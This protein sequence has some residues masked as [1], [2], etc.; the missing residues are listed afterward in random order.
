MQ[1]TFIDEDRFQSLLTN[2]PSPSPAVVADVLKKGREL[3]G[4]TPEE[5]A[6][7]IHVADQS[8]IQEIFDTAFHIKNTVYGG[9]LV[10]FAPLY[11]SNF[12]VNN[13]R[14]C[15]FRAGNPAPRKK[16][17]IDEIREQTDCL[18][19]MGHKRILLETGEDA[20]NNPID[21]V[22]DAIDAI[23][24]IKN[25]KGEV[26]RVN[27]NIAATTVENYRRLKAKGI[28][29]YQL[30]QESYHRQ[31][32]ENVHYGLKGNYLR[33]LYAL[34]NAFEGGIDDVGM[35][36][37]F[38]LYDW[39]FE[40]LC[41]ISHA[42]YL[43]DKFGIGPHTISVPRLRPATA[44]NLAPPF[45]VSDSDFLKLIA[46]LRI[47]VPYTGMIITTRERPEI[48]EEAFRLGITQ[49]SA[50]SSTAPGGFKKET[51]KESGQFELSDKRSLDEITASVMKQGFMPSFC[52]ACYRRNRTGAVFMELAKPGDIHEFC[53][54]NSVLT[55]MEYLE[56]NAS[57]ESRR[58]GMEL[59]NKSL[60]GI[61]NPSV[62]NETEERLVRIRNGERDLYF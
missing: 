41:L 10:F 11:I 39:R 25:E 60:E 42:S 24:S 23:Y 62:R 18:I 19:R 49:A 31:T 8:F 2:I 17:T 20:G 47:A 21:Y 44:V 6:I 3:K 48:R 16:L 26:R 35:G 61:E 34:D 36:V 30:F 5:A 53:A 52:T 13:C 56:D 38:G 37:L 22:L 59:I 14:Y 29:T 54:P 51:A 12:C 1:K 50:A 55:L 32:Y 33:Q 43:M 46:I 7:L 4:L 45:P 27:V 40:T 9:R 15:G 28:G 57:A 58:L